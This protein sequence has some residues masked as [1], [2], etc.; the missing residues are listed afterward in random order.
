MIYLT[1]YHNPTNQSLLPSPLKPQDYTYT[2]K[3]F[4][5][6]KYTH[7]LSD[8]TSLAHAHIWYKIEIK[9]FVFKYTY[10]HIFVYKPAGS[11]HI[12]VHFTRLYVNIIP[13]YIYLEIIEVIRSL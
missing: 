11:A 6:H 5:T 3:Q 8:L 7:T 13:L 4:F 12:S 2:P 1:P 10:L 9:F